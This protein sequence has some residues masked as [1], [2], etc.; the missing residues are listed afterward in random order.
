MSLSFYKKVI[1]VNSEIAEAALNYNTRKKRF[2]VIPAFVTVGSTNQSHIPEIAKNFIQDHS[3][4]VCSTVLFSSEYGIELLLDAFNRIRK[5]Y[6]KSGLV[7]IGGGKITERYKYLEKECL[8]NGS[9]L[10]LNQISHQSCVDIISSSDL[11]VRASFADGDSISIRE[12]L[13]SFVTVLASDA[14]PRPEGTV[15]FARGNLQDLL[16]KL[17]FCFE[18]L[19]LLKSRLDNVK[20]EG[21]ENRVFD[22]Y[23]TL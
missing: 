22:V 16:E 21:F 2:V 20:L 14:A 10:V 4:L 13:S 18:N 8:S 23:R 12:A 19:S 15:L 6:P 1:C 11:F 7:I 9:L 17:K 5:R 3:P